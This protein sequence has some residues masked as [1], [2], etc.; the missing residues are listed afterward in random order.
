[1]LDGAVSDLLVEA[2]YVVAGHIEEV[3]RAGP[4]TSREQ[5]LRDRGFAGVSAA[6][7][8]KLVFKQVRW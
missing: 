5:V 2:Q 1:M 3:V 7:V 8:R 4:S 6:S